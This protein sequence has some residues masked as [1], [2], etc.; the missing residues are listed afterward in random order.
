MY[1]QCI[2]VQGKGEEGAAMYQGTTYPIKRLLLY[3]SARYEA[4]RVKQCLSV[5]EAFVGLLHN[6]PQIVSVAFEDGGLEA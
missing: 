6:G 4:I 3:R 2:K 1:Q 5:T